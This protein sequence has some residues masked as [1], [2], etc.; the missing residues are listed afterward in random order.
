MKTPLFPRFSRKSFPFLPALC[1][2]AAFI[3]FAPLATAFPVGGASTECPCGTASDHLAKAEDSRRAAAAFRQDAARFRQE[4]EREKKGI[5]IL[6]KAT[7]NPWWR[8]A[9]LHYEPL[10]DEAERRAA[11]AERLVEYHR[12]RAAEF[13]VP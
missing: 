5:A 10:I 7:E 4:L 11:E 12:L 6:P 3:T 9:R 1:C 2:L 13:Q 8:K